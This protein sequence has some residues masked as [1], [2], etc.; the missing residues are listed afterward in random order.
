MA[1]I[2]EYNRTALVTGASA[3]IGLE[4]ARYLAPHVETLIT[5]A[6]RVERMQ[7]FAR[8]I[9]S[10]HPY[11][12]VVVQECDLSNSEAAFA[13]VERLEAMGPQVDI[14]VNNAGFGE[15][16]LFECS[17]WGRTKC[18]CDS[19]RAVDTC[20]CASDGAPWP[21]GSAEHRVRRRPRG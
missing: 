3:G 6:R 5:V 7:S 15:N 19:R 16:T 4:I 20:A 13:M 18:Q 11:V 17:D 9:E 14:L 10:A 8:E 1:S 12:K 2:F 21:R